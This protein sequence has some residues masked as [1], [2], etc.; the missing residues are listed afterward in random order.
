MT[1]KELAQRIA[2]DLFINGHNETAV[3]LRLEVPTGKGQH[4]KDGG[5]Y[6]YE[7]VVDTVKKHLDENIFWK[8]E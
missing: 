1:T 6:C 7:A 8:P 5:G 4:I 2:K 3:R